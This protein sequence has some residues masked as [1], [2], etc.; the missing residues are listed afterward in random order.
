MWVISRTDGSKAVTS[1][2]AVEDDFTP[3]P[4]LPDVVTSETRGLV[5]SKLI[6]QWDRGKNSTPSP[7]PEV[8]PIAVP[9][10]LAPAASLEDVDETSRPPST[11]KIVSTW[12]RD[13]NGFRT[14]VP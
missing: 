6:D 13:Q 7:Q 1:P 8:I 5:A 11:R 12:A 14:A 9:D 3:A 2:I 10:V 4:S